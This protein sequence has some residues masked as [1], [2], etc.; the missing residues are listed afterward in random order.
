VARGGNTP[1]NPVTPVYPDDGATAFTRPLFAWNETV[2]PEGDAVTYHVQISTDPGFAE[3]DTLTFTTVETRFQP[4]TSQALQDLTRYY[5]R[6]VPVDAFGAKPALHEV[7]SFTTDNANPE[8]PGVLMGYVRDGATF[9]P[10]AA[11]TVQ[12]LPTGTTTTTTVT[13]SYLVGNLPQGLY[14][15]SVSAPGYR[16]ATV[17]GIAIQSGRFTVKDVLLLYVGENRSPVLQP[18]GDRQM[19]VGTRLELLCQASDP[20]P[21][22]VLTWSVL[23]APPRM[24]M[25]PQTGLLVYAPVAGDEGDHPIV[26]Q[27]RD[28]HNPPLT[29][30]EA[31]TITVKGMNRPPLLK[32]IDDQKIVAG[33]RLELPCRAADP[34]PDDTI[35]WRLVS[36]PP[37][38][39]INANTG[40]L[41][42]E[43]L[44][45]DR[46]A[47]SV[48]V[49]ITD[50]GLPPL[51][52][53]ESFTITV[54]KANHAPVIQA[55]RDQYVTAGKTLTVPCLADDPDDGDVLSWNLLSPPPR[56]SIDPATGLL[57]YRPIEE[58]TGA[59][60]VT[61]Q[62]VDNGTPPLMGQAAFSVTVTPT[63]YVSGPR[64]AVIGDR[65][66]LEYHGEDQP[67]LWHVQWEHEGTIL[68]DQNDELLVIES[69]TFED[70]GWYTATQISD[71]KAEP[72]SATFYLTVYEEMPMRWA[73]ALA[74]FVCV[75]LLV[76]RSTGRL[77]R[78]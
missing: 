59:R 30:L 64:Y 9:A 8:I 70:A 49:E 68:P 1:P 17:T 36:A 3:A 39:G 26:V 75:T 63:V 34:D 58:D 28:N 77:G 20:D 43:P 41:V 22:D 6:V 29:A 67:G 69:V 74:A 55:P 13:G 38:M 65:V 35:T 47:F 62:V 19:V 57:T 72:V 44:N 16:S 40:L 45:E 52:A 51:S 14:D 78:E 37:R 71:S 66:E 54:L 2:D 56:M 32:A 15:I 42:Y 76:I 11:A 5:W 4:G 10:L 61:V 18:V 33:D 31:I 60:T 46:G 21:G 50:D 25:D 53:S 23:N 48:T 27:V 12:M 73:M 7:R 24:T